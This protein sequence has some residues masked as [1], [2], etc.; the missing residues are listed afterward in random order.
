MSFPP[1]IAERA[2]LDSGRHCCICHVFCGFKIELHHIVQEADDG[3]DSYENCIPLCLNCHAEVK[4]YDHRHPKGRKYTESELRGHRDRWYAKVQGTGFALPSN[5]IQIGL[6]QEIFTKLRKIIPYDGTI[7]FIRDHDFGD[8][9]DRRV[10][11]DFK[12]FR[13]ECRYNPEFEFIDADLEGVRANL[14]KHIDDFL[15]CLAQNTFSDNRPGSHLIS[16]QKEFRYSKNESWPQIVR[17][18]NNAAD[19]VIETYDNL[20][21][22][23]RR[24]LGVQ[25]L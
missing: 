4:A 3:D 7:S 6:D 10:I 18:I 20:I 22:L 17:E 24:K 8:T 13:H 5:Q 12:N 15:N 25:F 23:C 11:K 16:V 2:L 9:F 21:R 19:K 1:D 14:F